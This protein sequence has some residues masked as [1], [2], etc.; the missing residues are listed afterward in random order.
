MQGEIRSAD[1]WGCNGRRWR[2]VGPDLNDAAIEQRSVPEQIGRRQRRQVG[3]R[4]GAAYR[5]AEEVEGVAG[6]Q[7]ITK[8]SHG[9]RAVAREAGGR[10]KVGIL[11][12]GAV[13]FHHVRARAV[14]RNAVVDGEGANANSINAEP[15]FD[16]IRKKL[17]A[18]AKSIYHYSD[19]F[20]DF[21]FFSSFIR[22]FRWDW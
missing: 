13:E 6:L 3:Y 22:R 15:D 4:E 7:W 5:G 11:R 10:E 19:I 8:V 12:I 2:H 14:E 16:P 17:V 1:G 9:Q 21:H 20:T 18:I